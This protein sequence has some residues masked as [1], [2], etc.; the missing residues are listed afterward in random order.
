[1]YDQNYKY[2]LVIRKTLEAL[3]STE[4]HDSQSED[5]KKLE[6]YAKRVWFSNGIH[7]HYNNDKFIPECSQ[8]FFAHVLGHVDDSKL[9]LQAGQTKA[10]FINFIT[11]LIFDEKIAAKK[12]SLD[13]KQDLVKSSAVNFYEGVTQKEAMDF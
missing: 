5:F 8:E 11:P 7:H 12:V 13:S 4:S 10:D 2:N 9:P 6:I 1:Y 3:L